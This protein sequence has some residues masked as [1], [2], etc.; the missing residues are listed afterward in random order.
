MKQIVIALAAIASLVGAQALAADMEVKAPPAPAAATASWTGLYLDAEA[1]WEQT[2]NTWN[3]FAS[4]LPGIAA[5]PFT[6]SVSNGVLGGHIGYQQQFGWI[7]AG[8]EVGAFTPFNTKFATSTPTPAP[9]APPCSFGTGAQCQVTVGSVT[10]A[11][12]KIGLAW[13]DWLIY[14]VGGS[15]FNAGVAS[16]VIFAGLP[17]ETSSSAT[18]KGYYVGG[19]LDYLLLKTTFGDLIGGIEYQ[20]I[21]LGNVLVLSSSNG[22]LACAPGPNCAQ[23]N[24]GTR[25]DVVWGKLTVKFNPFGP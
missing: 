2:T 24:I 18:A 5:S 25:E 12:G 21:D 3:Y 9:G 6:A 11:G 1:G 8:A 7:V 17:I 19:G 23:R 13:Q 4:T 20:H 10:T 14:G 22:F 16:Q 15:A